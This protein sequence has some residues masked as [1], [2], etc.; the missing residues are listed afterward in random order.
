MTLEIKNGSMRT[1]QGPLFGGLNF[2]ASSGEIV[3]IQGAHS[4]GKTMLLRAIMGFEP[5]SEGFISIDGEL[6]N[7]QS[8]E[9]FRRLMGYVPQQASLPFLSMNHMLTELYALKANRSLGTDAPNPQRQSTLMQLLGLPDALAEK[10][11]STLTPAQNY[12]ITLAVA[13]M[14]NKQILLIDEPASVLDSAAAQMVDN[15]IHQLASVGT[16]VVAVS[17]DQLFA[18][19]C[20][21][22]VVLTPSS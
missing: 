18:Q 17:H 14:L 20:N 8:A 12:R 21:R 7:V 9:T 5:L 10:P 11:L 2:R 15:F 6:L 22:T 13:A 3:C 1:A 19:S 16:A 4:S